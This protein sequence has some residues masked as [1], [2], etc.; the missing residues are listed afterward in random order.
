[1][2]QPIQPP[3][4]ITV[5]SG[6]QSFGIA[7]ALGALFPDAVVTPRPLPA[8]WDDPDQE[9][10]CALQ[11]SDQ[12]VWVSSSHCNLLERHLASAAHGPRLIT[13]PVIGFS[14]FHP[15]I[16]YAAK[17]STG[18]LTV[19][20]YNSAIAVWAYR[21]RVLPEDAQHLF[22]SRVFRDLG[23]FNEWDANVRALRQAFAESALRAHFDTFFLH[24][25]RTGNF[26]YS[27]N[28][29][30]IHVLVRLAQ[31][32]ALELGCGHAVLNQH[33]E[34][35]DFLS[36]E[37][38]P[39]YPEVARELSIPGGSHHW[40]INAN[41]QLDGV[42]AYIDFAFNAYRHQGIAPEDIGMCNRDDALFDRVLFSAL[43]QAP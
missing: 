8:Q 18:E 31:A 11:L 19:H 42:L 36:H 22:T 41:T 14:A 26:M 37:S 16:C 2:P 29:P 10:A 27:I 20:H 9:R 32:I 30:R 5:N 15:D 33:M 1:M 40:K 39:M 38:W 17:Q 3:K 34:V 21:H 25:Q 43:G 23:Y 12:D 28:H 6:C 4:A 13:V 24:I 35:D 7:A